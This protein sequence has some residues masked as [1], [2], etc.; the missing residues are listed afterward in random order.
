MIEFIAF[1]PGKPKK[2]RFCYDILAKTREQ[3]TREES[4]L[5]RNYSV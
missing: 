2:Q 1:S 3:R 5:S 4:N